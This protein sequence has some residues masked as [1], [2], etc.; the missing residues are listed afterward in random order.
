MRMMVLIVYEHRAS[1]GSQSTLNSRGLIDNKSTE[2]HL[3][4]VH[5]IPVFL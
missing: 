3:L 1:I 5:D 4:N 2:K